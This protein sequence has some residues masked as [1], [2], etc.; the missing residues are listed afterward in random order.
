MT[1][2]LPPPPRYA[3]FLSSVSSSLLFYYTSPSI[4]DPFV[5]H[6]LT[7]F[8]TFL[9]FNLFFFFYFFFFLLTENRLKF[10]IKVV[11]RC[12][13]RRPTIKHYERD[14]FRSWIDW[15]PISHILSP[16]FPSLPFV[17][18]RPFSSVSVSFS[19]FLSLGREP[20]RHSHTYARSHTPT[21]SASFLQDCVV[22]FLVVTSFVTSL[23]VREYKLS[24][25]SLRARTTCLKVDSLPILLSSP[26]LSSPLCHCTSQFFTPFHPVFRL[27][28]GYSVAIRVVQPLTRFRDFR[29]VDFRETERQK[30]RERDIAA[31]LYEV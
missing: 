18:S 13:D 3:S 16:L 17:S 1:P 25:V 11:G 19:F 26:L 7:Q 22:A 12:Y 30:R 29:S 10:V 24:A 4:S 28:N 21:C 15:L 27:Q 20:R 5:S 23:D 6:H 8:A 2:Q 9:L 31:C 14:K